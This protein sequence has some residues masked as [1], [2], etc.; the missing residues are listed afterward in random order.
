MNLSCAFDTV[1]CQNVSR[2]KDL[3]LTSGNAGSHTFFLSKESTNTKENSILRSRIPKD[4]H[5][6]T[7]FFAVSFA[8]QL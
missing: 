7:S 5:C 1:T 4:H 8:P 2:E 6:K 3:F